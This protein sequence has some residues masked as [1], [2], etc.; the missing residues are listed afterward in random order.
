MY[1]IIETGGKQYWVIPGELVHVGKLEAKEGDTFDLQALWASEENESEKATQKATVT[2]EIV[3]HLK[4]RK[5][6]VFKK[7]PKSH[8]R[9]TQG[10]RQDATEIR[11][12][13][14]SLN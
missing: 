13:K 4:E 7:R 9:R 6:V 14:I 5:V 11:I 2:V 10:H 1:A 3:R 8:Y 12:K